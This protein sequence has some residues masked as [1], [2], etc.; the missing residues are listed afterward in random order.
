MARSIIGR[1]MKSI[2]VLSCPLRV[3]G[4]IRSTQ[5]LVQGIVSALF[6][7]STVFTVRFL[8]FLATYTL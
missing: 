2:I 7:D 8:L 1:H 5:T 6:T 3:Y 4:P